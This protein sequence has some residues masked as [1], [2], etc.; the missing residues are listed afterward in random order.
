M[1]LER[2]AMSTPAELYACL[3]A[4]E[5]PAQALLR[6]RPV[7]REQACVVMEGDP[8]LEQV[9][10]LNQKARA[11]GMAR[12]MT[13]TEVE[14]FAQAAILKRSPQ[15]E[16]A[17]K[18][19]LL[20]C[21]GGF[22]PRV[23]EC[24]KDGAFLCAI[25]I[26]GTEKLF[27]A[28]AALAQN[29]RARTRALGFAASVSIC[30]NFHAGLV[31]AKGLSAGS[32]PQV[33]AAGA[34]KDTLAALPLTVL[35]LTEEQ[36]E[37]FSLWGIRA[38]GPLGDLPE[39]ELIARMG[40]EGKR[41]RQLAR[42]RL[43]HLFQPIEPE[44]TL[45]ECAEL[46]APVET[47]DALLFV[48]NLL[49]EQILMR[50]AA[51]FVAAASITTTLALES[52]GTH[53]RT[54]R[55][56]LPGNDRQVW[57]K[58]IHLDLVAHPP[59]AGVLSV[60]LTAEP[61]RTAKVQLGLFAPQ[62]PE[63]ARLDVTLARLRALVGEENAGRA[64]LDDTHAQEAFHL[65]AFQVSTLRAEESRP[66]HR[67][68]A[69]RRVRPAEP[70]SVALRG[71]QPAALSFRQLFYR[72]ER[73]YGPWLTS[74]DWWKPARWSCEQWDVVARAPNGQM[75]CCC[76]VRDMLRNEWQMAALYD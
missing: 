42:G 64:V 62:L 28:P 69:Q 9:C 4:K 23:E 16:T 58:L 10:S 29:L 21:A 43:P 50:A 57:L 71:E 5:F 40:Q 15:A 46:D 44:F 34:E 31:A 45:A 41:L 18:A 14:T 13:Q 7:L 6:T 26:A 73:A 8:P 1:P 39:K 74:G 12:G 65:E 76:I 25:D 63:P 61:G 67:R 66:S 68:L 55:L 3:C 60:T 70:I 36:L 32:G 24:S 27:G 20:E 72:I 37:T 56:A 75:L 33:I 35:D 17:A 47:L 22:S 11:I 30:H 2:N 54:V 38:L 51:R 59:P 52:G 19:V 53:T 49:L 48:A